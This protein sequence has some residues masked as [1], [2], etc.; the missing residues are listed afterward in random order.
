MR[1]AD[2]VPEYSARSGAVCCARPWWMYG[3]NV[4]ASSTIVLV[5]S[6]GWSRS[7]ETY[8]SLICCSSVVLGTNGGAVVGVV[9]GTTKV[10]VGGAGDVVVVLSPA[11]GS[12]RS[13]SSTRS[14]SASDSGFSAFAGI[15]LTAR[16]R[17]TRPASRNAICWYSAPGHVRGAS[18]RA[19]ENVVGRSTTLTTSLAVPGTAFDDAGNS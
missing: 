9:G 19:P 14:A 5:S 15:R 16:T 4:S 8:R 13:V 18:V 12:T 1:I 11:S 10:G 2:T 17:N 3:S 6:S 7:H